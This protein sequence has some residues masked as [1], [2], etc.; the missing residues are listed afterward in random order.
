MYGETR[1]GSS[2]DFHVQHMAATIG[3]RDRDCV[4]MHGDGPL[5]AGAVRCAAAGR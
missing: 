5:D 2:L 3:R 4:V 1:G